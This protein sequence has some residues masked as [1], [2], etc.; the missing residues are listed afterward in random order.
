MLH[1][2]Q[3]KCSGRK[4]NYFNNNLYNKNLFYKKFR[5]HLIFQPNQRSKPLNC[6]LTR[7]KKNRSPFDLARLIHRGGALEGRKN[8]SSKRIALVQRDKNKVSVDISKGAA[9][10]D[11]VKTNKK[12]TLF[13][14]SFPLVISTRELENAHPLIRKLVSAREVPKLSLARIRKF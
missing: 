12:E 2:S 3:K 14:R 11:K 10:T 7:V 5:E 4:R 9:A 13:N 1:S 8:S 6:L